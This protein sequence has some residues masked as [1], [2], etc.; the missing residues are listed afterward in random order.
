MLNL[1]DKKNRNRKK[2]RQR[3]K[4]IVQIYEQCC[5]QKT[6]ENLRNR[7]DVR[8]VRNKKDYLKWTSKP[9]Y[10][11]QEIFNN[12]LVA[13]CKSKATLTLSKAGYVGMCM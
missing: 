4:S 8:L 10:M 12:D 3:L 2:W 5:I 13:I 9:N 6:M 11:L 1:T 7:I